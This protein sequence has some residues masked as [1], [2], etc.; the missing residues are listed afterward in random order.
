MRG[1]LLPVL[2]PACSEVLLLVMCLMAWTR[3]RRLGAR[4]VGQ[5]TLV[6]ILV[7]A[8]GQVWHLLEHLGQPAG[9]TWLAHASLSYLM[10]YVLY[11]LAEGVWQARVSCS[12]LPCVAERWME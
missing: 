9:V 2:V 5:W 12:S 10:V 7:D 11:R 4:S 3:V 1:E 8:C 6:A